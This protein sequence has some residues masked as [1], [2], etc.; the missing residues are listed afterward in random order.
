MEAR[1]A[2]ALIIALFLFSFAL[3]YGIRFDHR[4]P[5]H[6]DE[7]DHL[8]IVKEMDKTGGIVHYDPYVTFLAF[9]GERNLEINYDLFL[10][11]LYQLTGLPEIHL[12][13]IIPAIVAFLLSLAS[14]VLVRF[15]VKDNLAALLSALFVL[16]LHNNIALLGYWF[17]V[18]MALG[19]AFIPLISYLFLKG[20][21]SWGYALLFLLVLVNITLVHAVYTVV[22]LPVFA[23]YL[24][25]NKNELKRNW[26]KILLGVAALFAVS[27]WFVA[28]NLADL[29]G[30]FQQIMDR[31]VWELWYLT[32]AY[33][34]ME[35]LT[36]LML[37]L[38]LVGLAYLLLPW[39]RF[40]LRFYG[41]KLKALA[42]KKRIAKPAEDLSLDYPKLFLLFLFILFWVR[43]YAD[44]F[45][46]C[47]LGPCRRTSPALSVMVL[48]MAGIGCWAL[49]KW[50][51]QTIV[52]GG[53]H[54]K[55]KSLL[56]ALVFSALGIFVLA[57]LLW[58]P[59]I[60]A[61]KLYYTLE[62]QELP[63]MSF[64]KEQTPG[65]ALFLAM[66]SYSKPVYVVGERQVSGTL[67]ARIGQA[68]G[69]LQPE[70]DFLSADCAGKLA[71][72]E[73]RQADY[74]YARRAVIDCQGIDKLYTDGN[75]YV[76][77]KS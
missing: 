67:Q 4:L 68:L 71:S 65:D 72:L 39:A 57:N 22:F 47:F 21:E 3:N 6:Q 53:Q 5:I 23:V 12:P 43:S 54:W 60:H 29:P 31:L 2:Y 24:L 25:L 49:I 9:P 36:P 15:L 26:K 62:E 50:V 33:P 7:F 44:V 37:G 59:F 28:W 18:P 27:N 76:Y 75:Y 19:V 74:I 41:L 16:F 77:G 55:E 69:Q 52:Q 11:I 1:Y 8:A 48:I 63:A 14:F 34:I 70:K 46:V 35:Y 13:L 38:G 61:D 42:A 66:P 73:E 30:T 51:S 58:Q 40:R 64:I 17:L 32:K 20:L 56:K 45:E 10:L